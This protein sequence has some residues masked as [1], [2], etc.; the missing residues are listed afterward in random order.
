MS[1][2]GLLLCMDVLVVARGPLQSHSEEVAFFVYS[3]SLLIS[4][5][6]AEWHWIVTQNAW[7]KCEGIS[8]KRA[9]RLALT[10]TDVPYPLN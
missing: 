10:L 2:V 7:C 6:N 1:A 8:P 9:C 4:L 3:F 5:A